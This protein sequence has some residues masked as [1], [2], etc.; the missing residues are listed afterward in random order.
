M[1]SPSRPVA[2][3]T[4]DYQAKSQFTRLSPDSL[5]IH[6]VMIDASKTA[7]LRDFETVE[8]RAA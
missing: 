4:G 8:Y 1:S 6:I 5:R 7:R 3:T 2:T